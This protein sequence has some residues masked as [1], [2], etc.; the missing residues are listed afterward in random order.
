MRIRL[1]SQHDLPA[2]LKIQTS[3]AQAA[4]WAEADYQRLAA[5]SQGLILVAEQEGANPGQILG[6]AAFHRVNEEA[7][8]WNLAVFPQYRRQGIG[9][10]LFQEA[11]RHLFDAGATRIFLEVRA[12]NEPALGLYQAVRFKHL[13]RRKDY[14]QNPRE[15]ALVLALDL[16]SGSRD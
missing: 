15:D 10:A 7:E 14:Y 11:C 3:S 4:A 9:K 6:F 1:F 16:V 8:L 12:S 2:I 13:S 5:N